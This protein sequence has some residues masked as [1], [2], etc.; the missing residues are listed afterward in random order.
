MSSARVDG[1][2][3]VPLALVT[4]CMGAP[5]CTSSSKTVM[6]ASS[7]LLPLSIISTGSFSPEVCCRYYPLEAG[8]RRRLLRA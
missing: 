4:V 3:F 5:V 1:V 2:T 6:N 8:I 7:R